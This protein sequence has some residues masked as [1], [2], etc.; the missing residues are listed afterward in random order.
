MSILNVSND[1]KFVETLNVPLIA[2]LLLRPNNISTLW[3]YS[4]SNC[5]KDVF[6]NTTHC[7]L[8]NGVTDPSQCRSYTT[9][10][11]TITVE[12]LTP[13]TSYIFM[14]TVQ[15]VQYPDIISDTVKVEITTL[16][17]SIGGRSFSK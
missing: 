8:V 13:N 6:F 1:F 9:T 2:H 16:G 7:L 15:S 3:N 5:Y 12:S 4:M 17:R 14:I 11:M 10:N